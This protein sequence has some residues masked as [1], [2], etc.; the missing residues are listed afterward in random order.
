M[1]QPTLGELLTRPGV[2]R[3]L[4]V[5]RDR[6]RRLI[7]VELRQ[8]RTMQVCDLLFRND[9]ET[10]RLALEHEHL[11]KLAEAG[12]VEWD[13]ETDEVTVGPAF[14]EVEPLLDLIERHADELPPGWP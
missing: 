6:Y 13:W 8:E 11:P 2:N 4:D 12:Y 5:C 7:L 1:G 14:E 3:V 10:A 9:P